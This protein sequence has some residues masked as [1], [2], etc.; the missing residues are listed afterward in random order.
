M[1]KCKVPIIGG[2]GPIDVLNGIIEEYATKTGE[3]DANSFVEFVTWQTQTKSTEMLFQPGG[4]TIDT[5]YINACKV[6]D[7][8]VFVAYVQSYSMYGCIITISGTSLTYGTPVKITSGSRYDVYMTPKPVLISSS[9][10]AIA[11]SINDGDNCHG[12]IIIVSVSGTS[13]TV[14]SAINIFNATGNGSLDIRKVSSSTA[15]VVYS[16]VNY[17]V[18]AAV[19]SIS[20]TTPSLGTEVTLDS[21]SSSIAN[22]GYGIALEMLSSSKAIVIYA[23][24][25]SNI[26]AK[27]LSISGTSVSVSATTDLWTIASGSYDRIQTTL[28]L[29]SPNTLLCGQV[30]TYSSTSIKYR[31]LKVSGASITYGA[32]VFVGNGGPTWPAIF[33]VL[34]STEAMAFGRGDYPYNPNYYYL[35]ISGTVITISKAEA[36][37][38]AYIDGDAGCGGFAI[39]V[40]NL[41][42]LLYAPRIGSNNY[43]RYVFIG[44][45]TNYKGVKPY[46]TKVDGLLVSKA[47]TTLKGK[48]YVPTI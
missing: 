48:V 29:L 18:Y 47:T 39:A 1:G 38:D 9:K 26:T 31:V 3:I 44:T 40:N 14:G 21:T 7:T 22:F 37:T 45:P 17:A 41:A 20:G 27:V 46:A 35:T 11:C 33:C 32:D 25:T 28:K 10:I 2:G 6:S 8:K 4:T 16:T 23:R 24:N 19:V 13:I 12:S 34:S 30:T 36:I 43:S 15:L 42:L 5:T